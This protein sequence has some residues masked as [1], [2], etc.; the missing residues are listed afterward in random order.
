MNR[1]SLHA[2][3]HRLVESNLFQNTVIAVIVV[4]AVTLGL[5]TSQWA[6]AHFGGLLTVLDKAAIGFFVAE[7]VLKLFAY[8][9]RFFLNAWNIF[10]F[11]VVVVTLIP[12]S[13]NVSVLRALRIIRA[14]RLISAVTG[15]RTVIEGLLR[16]LPGM[17]SIAMLLLL[18][19]YVASV[20]ATMM[21]GSEFDAWFGSVPRSAY[22]LFQI[23]TLE[24]WS[25]GVVRPVMETYP[26]AWAFFVTFILLSSFTGLNLFIAIVVSAVNYVSA[27][28]VEDGA[29]LETIS[30]DIAQLR[31]EV[32][33]LAGK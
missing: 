9:L 22:S 17:S 6:V 30:R 8:R 27:H 18:L 23:M 15:M 2:R 4:N 20:M 16:A 7:L 32:G 21:F 12:A 19:F 14:F 25:M 33:E 13:D 26:Y 24:S 10:D 11:I 1:E 5:E 3:A 29:S 31:R 28:S